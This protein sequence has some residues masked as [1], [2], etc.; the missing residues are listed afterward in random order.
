MV[1]ASDIAVKAAFQQRMEEIKDD[2]L[3]G[4]LTIRNAPAEMSERMLNMLALNCV[5]L[6]LAQEVKWN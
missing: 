4:R 1:A 3:G 5:L 2:I 6:L